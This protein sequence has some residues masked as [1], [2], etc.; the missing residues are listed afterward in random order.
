[1][2]IKILGVMCSRSYL[3]NQ[4]AVALG[5][6]VAEELI[7]GVENITTGASND[8]QQVCHRLWVLVLAGRA[9][10]SP[11]GLREPVAQPPAH[12][13]GCAFPRTKHLYPMSCA[14][15]SCLTLSGMNFESI[16]ANLESC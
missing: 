13:P 3:E 6:R 8:F 4:L 10:H 15:D 12:Q 7:F 11:E 9:A 5:G 1:M 14:S 2:S 16:P